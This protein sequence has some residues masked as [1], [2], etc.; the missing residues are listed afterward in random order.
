MEIERKAHP[1]YEAFFS[2]NK[3]EMIGNRDTMS[4]LFKL[5]DSSERL[6]IQGHPT[7]EFAKS[8]GINKVLKINLNNDIFLYRE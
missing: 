6:V 3:E 5:L 1:E 2:E 8:Q 7:K 4:L